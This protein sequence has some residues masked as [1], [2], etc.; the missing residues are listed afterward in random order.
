MEKT[1]KEN[2]N[3]VGLDEGNSVRQD[4]IGGYTDTTR[5]PVM[6]TNNW[7]I[8]GILVFFALIGG[9]LILGYNVMYSEPRRMDAAP[10]N[11]VAPP[12]NIPASP[13]PQ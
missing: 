5:F 8:V 1:T 9:I 3:D 4:H 7:T 2:P 11:D 10:A 13:T 6:N 12:P